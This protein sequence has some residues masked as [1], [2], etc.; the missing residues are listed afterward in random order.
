MDN[1]EVDSLLWQ[2]WSIAG[3]TISIGLALIAVLYGLSAI[4]QIIQPTS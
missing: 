4:L 1:E 3:L 2:N